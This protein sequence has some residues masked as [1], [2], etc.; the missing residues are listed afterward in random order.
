MQVTLHTP[1]TIYTPRHVPSW[2]LLS[3]SAGFVN[4]FA[5][6]VCEQ[7]VT[8]VTGTVTRMGLE[9]TQIGIA[10]EYFAVFFS[11]VAGAAAAVIVVQYRARRRKHDR[12]IIP[13]LSVAAIL[14]LVALV[15][16]KGGFVPI[17]V[18]TNDPPPVFLL[19]LLA[20][21]A[22]LQNASVASTTGMSVRTTH[23]T[24]PTTDI[25]MLLG[26]ALLGSGE[27][28]RTALNGAALRGGMVFSFLLGA[29][30]ALTVTGWLGYLA[31]LVPAGFVMV[32]G[33]LSF[34]PS[35]SPSDFPF[36]QGST[37]SPPSGALAGLP[38]DA[39]PQE[40]SKPTEAFVPH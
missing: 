38:A 33:L 8:H 22:G 35:W 10:A 21:A 36:L 25:G 12:W 6:L 15:G 14:V 5:F 31:L 34:L 18:H 37:Q 24:G 28:R 11:F 19:S 13:L 7:F 27:E 4:G 23:L 30:F 20:F 40:P 32:A 3:G 26:A 39:R 16:W 9:W 1:Q 29:A 2:L 17:G